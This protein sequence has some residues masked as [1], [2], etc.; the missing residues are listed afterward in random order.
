MGTFLSNV[1][2]G[3]AVL[4]ICLVFNQYMHRFRLA[5]WFSISLCSYEFHINGVKLSAVFLLSL[6]NEIIEGK[7]WIV[8]K[9]FVLSVHCMCSLNMI[10]FLSTLYVGTISP[11][12]QCNSNKNPNGSGSG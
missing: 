2:K 11:T 3:V 1:L 8:K 10:L 7:P 4:I 5:P 9:N 12:F 6:M